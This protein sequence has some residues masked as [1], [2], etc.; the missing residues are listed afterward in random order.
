LSL[1]ILRLA[2]RIAIKMKTNAI[3]ILTLFFLFVLTYNARANEPPQAS[4]IYFPS[5]PDTLDEIQFLDTSTDPDGTIVSWYWDFGDGST[6]TV[7]N[8]THRYLTAGTY[9]VSL[10]V[11]D[12]EGAS[13]IYSEALTVAQAPAP[14]ANRFRLLMG[15]APQTTSAEVDQF[16]FDLEAFLDYA[17]TWDKTSFSIEAIA[18]I[19]GPELAILGIGTQL[20]FVA[21]EDQFVFA[22]PFDPEDRRLGGLQ[23]V[24][25]RFTTRL[26]LVGFQVEN[27]V[28]V[29]DIHFTYPYPR[30]V[31]T[32]M[33]RF[34][35]ILTLEATTIGGIKLTSVL[36]LCADP[37][38]TNVLKKK[39]FSGRVCD[40]GLGFTVEKLIIE[41]LVLG[42]LRLDSETEFRPEEPASET[43]TA[44]LALPGLDE[45]TA[46]LTSADI[47]SLTLERAILKLRSG[48]FTLTTVLDSAFTITSTS[49]IANL[50]LFERLSL[51]SSATFSPN[52]GLS[53]M[54][55]YALIPTD[56]SSR[57][58]ILAI[59]SDREWSSVT[60]TLATTLAQ[61]LALNLRARFL[62]SGLDEFSLDLGLTLPR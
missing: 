60:F 20:G 9:V 3:T 43:L 61:S 5:H 22:V 40:G 28:L 34:G 51:I 36:G 56:T 25:K 19:A 62:S 27:L 21:L 4:F 50:R 17:F 42:N 16:D 10:T 26:D 39:S 23:L 55:L 41:R 48:A 32:P 38:R 47:T 57:F 13:D 7:Q 30:P 53:N 8:P 18:G 33:Y 29:E 11:T 59:Y 49:L 15:M 45:L 54:T 52:T 1:T 24:K 44:R 31:Q 2:I 14:P 6:S 37:Q 35:D 46:V 12:N 58:T